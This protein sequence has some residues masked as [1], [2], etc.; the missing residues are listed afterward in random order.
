MFFS[1]ASVALQLPH[2]TPHSLII[3]SLSSLAHLLPHNPL[4]QLFFSLAYLSYL[5]NPILSM[6][7]SLNSLVMILQLLQIFTCLLP[8][9][10]FVLKSYPPHNFLDY[11]WK[12]CFSHP[13]LT[14]SFLLPLDFHNYCTSSYYPFFYA[15]LAP[16]PLI[17]V[18]T[19]LKRL[20]QRAGVEVYQHHFSN[21]ICSLCITVTFC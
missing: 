15:F 17:H 3:P 10:H 14:I 6:Y 2:S 5:L 13:N 21:S 12:Y 16:N 11:V 1:P 7:L 19:T 9:H 8:G 20:L 18:L 4:I